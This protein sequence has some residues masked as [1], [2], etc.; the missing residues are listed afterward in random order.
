[1]CQEERIK[2]NDL[3]IAHPCI[4]N[5]DIILAKLSK[6]AMKRVSHFPPMIGV[7]KVAFLIYQLS[8]IAIFV[9]MLFLE[10]RINQTLPFHAGMTVYIMGLVLLIIS[11]INFSKPSDN[12]IN[13]NGLYQLSRNPMYVAY[14]ISLAGISLLVQS[15]TLLRFVFLFQISAHWII[16]SEERW[17]IE[18]FGEEYRFYM[19]KVRRYI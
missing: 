15:L 16:L 8:T 4:S 13:Q 11:T 3:F 18:Q 9:T 10:F 12:G 7:E 5:K 6:S 19:N 2:V 17:C 1:M 14:F